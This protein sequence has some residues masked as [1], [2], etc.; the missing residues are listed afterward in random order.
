M[1]LRV[2]GKSSLPGGAWSLSRCRRAGVG[3][4]AEADGDFRPASCPLAGNRHGAAMK[5]GELFHQRE[6]DAESRMSATRTFVLL[7]EH[8]EDMGEEVGLYPFA[9]IEIGRASCRER[10]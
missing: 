8:L 5:L 4:Q 7:T 9:G 2:R 6:A 1:T 3:N 10:V